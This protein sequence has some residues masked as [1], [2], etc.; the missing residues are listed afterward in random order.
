MVPWANGMI[1]L[2]ALTIWAGLLKAL[3]E[4]TFWTWLEYWTTPTLVASRP[5]SISWMMSIMNLRIVSNSWARTLRE[6]SMMNTRS[7]GPD[8]HFGSAVKNGRKKGK[9]HNDN[10][11]LGPVYTSAPF[12]FKTIFENRWRGCPHS[13]CVSLANVYTITSC[14]LLYP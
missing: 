10:T 8:L 3:R 9:T 11:D 2:M 7:T 5:M 1:S 13:H 6:P 14:L 4:N 12:I